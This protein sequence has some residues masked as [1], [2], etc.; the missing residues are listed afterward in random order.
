MSY[1][2]YIYIYIYCFEIL[3]VDAVNTNYVMNMILAIAI[4]LSDAKCYSKD[5]VL[6]V[7]DHLG[8]LNASSGGRLAVG[9]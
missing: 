2:W 1:K 5:S 7:L 9:T 6:R 3:G 4:A 8:E